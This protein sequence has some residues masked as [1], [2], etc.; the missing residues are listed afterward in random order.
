[1][2]LFITAAWIVSFLKL[3]IWTIFMLMGAIRIVM[4]ATISTHAL[5]L[6][7]SEAASFYSS[8]VAIIGAIY[9]SYTARIDKLPIYDMYSAYFAIGLPLLAIVGSHFFNKFKRH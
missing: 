2:I 9:L 8:I 7:I 6:K 1:M 4:F 5:G 3:E